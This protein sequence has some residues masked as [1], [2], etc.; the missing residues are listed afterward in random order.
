MRDGTA[1]GAVISKEMRIFQS[2]IIDEN[3]KKHWSQNP[4][5]KNSSLDRKRGMRELHEETNVDSDRRGSLRAMSGD[6]LG[7]N[8]K[9]FW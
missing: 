1:E 4:V 6:C 5:L 7:Y 2:Q 3:Q 9:R 8:R